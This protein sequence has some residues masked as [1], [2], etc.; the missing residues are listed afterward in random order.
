VGNI[1]ELELVREDRVLY[2]T[3]INVGVMVVDAHLTGRKLFKKWENFMN[4]EDT[5]TAA[6]A[7]EIVKI[8]DLF[9]G[10]YGVQTLDNPDLWYL[11]DIN[12][13][14]KSEFGLLIDEDLNMAVVGQM[15]KGVD[16]VKLGQPEITFVKKEGN[17][18]RFTEVR[19]MSPSGIREDDLLDDNP[20]DYPDEVYIMALLPGGIAQNT[21]TPNKVYC[22]AWSLN[23]AHA[24]MIPW[25]NPNQVKTY[26]EKVELVRQS[27]NP[28]DSWYKVFLSK[29]IRITIDLSLAINKTI[30][31]FEKK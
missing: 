9:S 28:L 3:D 29:P 13:S 2:V 4:M 25:S 12:T 14:G 10:F 8:A 22:D 30:V 31:K 17:E 27:D 21:N 23:S 5:T 11:G 1:R 7:N 24:Q 6:G 26:M 18:F 15:D 16:I 19:R 20:F